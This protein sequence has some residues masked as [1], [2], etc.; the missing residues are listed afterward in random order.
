MSDDT[1]CSWHL[2]QHRNGKA[3]C[4]ACMGI[5]CVYATQGDQEQALDPLELEL[6]I[7]DDDTP[8]RCWEPNLV[9]LQRQPVLSSPSY[10][11]S[12]SEFCFVFQIGFLCSPGTHSPN[13]F[14]CPSSGIKDMNHHVQQGQLSSSVP[15]NNLQGLFLVSFRVALLL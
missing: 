3:G 10:F 2:A 12:P 8:G 6:H 15:K 13:C 9:P 14:C 4:S 5:T 1:S 7:Y 11:S